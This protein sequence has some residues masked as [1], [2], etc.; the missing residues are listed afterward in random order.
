MMTTRPARVWA[1]VTGGNALGRGQ[2]PA[3]SWWLP[4][5]CSVQHAYQVRTDD[6][7]D[8]GRVGGAIQSF[9]RLPVFDRSRRSA[10][11][12]VKVWTDLGESAWSDPVRLESGPLGEQDWQARCPRRRRRHRPAGRSPVRRVQEIRPAAVRPVHGPG[13]GPDVYVV[14]FGQNFSGWVRLERPA[15]GRVTAT[16][17]N[18]ASPRTASGMSVSRV[19]PARSA[20]M[21]SPASS[22]TPTCAGSAGSPAATTA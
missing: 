6:G 3:L 13:N 8:T 20:P 7:Y 4:A 14:D 9:V 17:S 5:R 1:E 10:L 2:Q 18:R 15:G 16:C 11:A 19:S 12:Q 21:T 22:C